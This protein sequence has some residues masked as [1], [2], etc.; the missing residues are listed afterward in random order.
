MHRRIY[1]FVGFGRRFARSLSRTFSITHV[2]YHNRG[3]ATLEDVALS[4]F[5]TGHL[6]SYYYANGAAWADIDN[7]VAWE[8]VN[9]SQ[10][11]ST[12]DWVIVAC[13]L[14]HRVLGAAQLRPQIA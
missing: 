6:A 4:A 1:Q 10:V 14:A 12:K 7:G 5:G 3:D 9:K 8:S 13:D 11:E 2:L